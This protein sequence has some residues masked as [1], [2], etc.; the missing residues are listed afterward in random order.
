[1]A[2]HHNNM[3]IILLTLN[4]LNTEVALDI[5]LLQK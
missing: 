3:T 4:N 1:V 5:I 2:S